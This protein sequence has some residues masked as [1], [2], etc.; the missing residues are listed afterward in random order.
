MAGPGEAG[1][2][3]PAKKGSVLLGWVLPILALT[4]VAAGGGGLIGMQIVSAVR[5]TVLKDAQAQ[6]IAASSIKIGMSAVRELAPIVT[7]LASPEGAVVRL[8][9][10][11]VY[12]K[13]DAQQ[14]DIVAAKIGDDML[15]FVK[16][17]TVAE[18]Q[19]AS[20]LQHLREDLNDRAA[21]R[22]DGR[23]HELMIEMLVVQ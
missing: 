8:Q 7:N 6:P 16:T 14:I 21:V 5:A 22:S 3:K 2:A 9:T 19:G 11:I 18:L 1:G 15:A 10:A 23:V 4:A 20:G 13:S 12:D 17:L